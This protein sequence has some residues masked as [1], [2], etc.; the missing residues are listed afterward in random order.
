MK[1]K[2]SIIIIA[3][4]FS[5][6]EN[7]TEI[8]EEFH[9]YK[10]TSIIET[11]FDD[12]P[13]MASY[14]DGTFAAIKVD[15]N[16][17]PEMVYHKLPGISP[18]L[19]WADENAL[20]THAYFEGTHIFFSNYS[21]TGVD[22]SIVDPKGNIEVLEN[23][24]VDLSAYISSNG[25]IANVSAINGAE[26]SD[27]VRWA[28]RGV[29]VAGCIVSVLEA[30]GTVGWL[31]PKAVY[32]CS[33]SLAGV[34]AEVIPEDWGNIKAS[35]DAWSQFVDGSLC[36]FDPTPGGKISCVSAALS[37]ISISLEKQEEKSTELETQIA[38]AKELIDKIYLQPIFFDF[39][40]N[41]PPEE[42][43]FTLGRSVVDFKNGRMN[44]YTTDASASLSVE[45]NLPRNADKINI[46]WD[47]YLNSTYWGMQTMAKIYF[48]E[49]S[50]LLAGRVETG[51]MGN[52]QH[53]VIYKEIEGQKRAIIDIESQP[54]VAGGYHFTATVNNQEIIIQM[55]NIE[56]NSIK[57]TL[58][59]PTSEINSDFDIQ[60]LYKLSQH[61][62]VT[63]GNGSWLDNLKV[64]F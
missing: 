4:F 45:G 55:Y 18:L 62:W 54:L 53:L 57:Q 17:F 61:I 37:L 34:M 16:G 59:L 3:L 9:P 14:K 23:I 27:I 41:Q 1:L 33:G 10:N 39:N 43:E 28:G 24:E 15:A 58:T 11:G 19:I 6:S 48:P 60:N 50:I 47:G 49:F 32:S 25:R 30:I 31:I 22:V 8:V 2:I 35:A 42:W 56:N 21:P 36:G 40:N 12:F 46:E 64:E 20:P 13:I 38:E 44:A 63:T 29:S 7:T 52:D 5:C 51:D 26:W